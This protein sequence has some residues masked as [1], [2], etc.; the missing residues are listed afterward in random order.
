MMT[1]AVIT[2]SI[3]IGYFVL[4]ACIIKV[5]TQKQIDL[6]T[7]AVGNRSF[8]VFLNAFSV[9]GA[10]Y[11]GAVYVGWVATSADTGVFAQYIIIYSTV[12]CIIQYYEARPVWIW[13]KEYGL[14]TEG[15]YIAK[16]YG[17]QKFRWIFMTILFIFY[18]PW[19]IVE[20]K[21]LGYMVH[22]ATYYTVGFEAAIIIG[23]G[24][25]TAYTFFGGARGTAVGGLVQGI[26]MGVVGVLFIYWLIYK[27]YGGIFDLYALVEEFKPQLLSIRANGAP[28]WTSVIITCGV[29]GFVL[30]GMFYR[31]YMTDSP[32]TTKKAV[33]FAPLLG[34]LMGFLV[35]AL[36]L[37][38]SFNE[39]FP[40]DSQ[41]TSFWMAEKFGG[42]VGLGILGVLGLAASMS[43]IAVFMNC[44]AVVIS[45]DIVAPLFP[46]MGRDKLFKIARLSTIGVG[47]VAMIISMFEV[48]QLMYFVIAIYDCCVQ[49]F[50]LV[51]IG[52]FWKKANLQGAISGFAIGSFWAVIG[53]FYPQAIAWAGGWTGGFIGLVCNTLA[54]VIC[55]LIFGKQSHVDEMFEVLKK[56]KEP[57]SGKAI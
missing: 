43:S 32:R 41:Q 47:V 46:K 54:V 39:G 29:G 13:G 24:F 12:A 28:F 18:A 40:E 38:A 17:S 26:T 3:M 36:G 23:A 21:A 5:S 49:A 51:F 14:E 1:D 45:K 34:I 48:A 4:N 44:F 9:V 27:A 15:D 33:L 8:G 19:L 20:I 2:I 30:P 52:L 25:V 6:E 53:I 57:R 35:M 22:A 37:G 56:Y 16:R 50:P 31:L 10:W 55:G 7:Y 11:V 42:P